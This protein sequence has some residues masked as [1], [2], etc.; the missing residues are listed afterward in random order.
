MKKTTL[1][2]VDFRKYHL[3]A[4]WRAGLS[5]CFLLLAACESM[6][7]LKRAHIATAI[8]SPTASPLVAPAHIDATAQGSAENG[9]LPSVLSC[10]ERAG[11]V[12]T[13]ALESKL[14][15]ATMD[16]AAYLP[17]CYQD[18]P[19]VR[20]PVLFLLHGSDRDPDQWAALGLFRTLDRA[21]VS[22]GL[23]PMLVI[24]PHVTDEKMGPAAIVAELLPA[25][26]NKFRM[27]ADR[28]HRGIGGVSRGADWALRIALG[29][30]DLFSSLGIF[31]LSPDASFWADL[32]S[33][34]RAVPEGLW[35][36]IYVD[37]GLSDTS[38]SQSEKLLQMWDGDARPYEKHFQPGDH[39]DA[40][41]ALR[42]PD[43]LAWY[44]QNWK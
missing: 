43:Y 24:L 33:L 6:Q 29:R 7:P 20:Y 30:A 2:L 5:A 37:I 21:V 19:A 8:P 17:P 31:S 44:S 35:P 14:I 28:E 11:A 23:P 18:S 9:A 41:W 1:P 40:Y 25:V 16:Y 3:P 22:G 4:F 26:E 15:G 38:L 42:L 36:R 13:S 34:T 32:P 27:I 39:S 12:Q 10:P